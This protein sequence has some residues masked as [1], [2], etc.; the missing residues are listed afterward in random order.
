ML[1]KQSQLEI[2]VDAKWQQK[3][4][5]L[6]QTDVNKA[7]RKARVLWRDAKQLQRGKNTIM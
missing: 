7:E 4:L 2:I 1:S 5:K 3:D 6:I